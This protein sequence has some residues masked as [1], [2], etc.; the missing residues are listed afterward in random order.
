MTAAPGLA[1]PGVGRRDAEVLAGAAILLVLVAAAVLA[2]VLT[3]WDPTAVDLL[4]QHESVSAAHLLGTDHLGRDVLARVLHAGRT[5][6]A[7]AAGVTVASGV[8]GT[9]L[10][11][12]C[13][14]L[15]GPLPAVVLRLVDVVA[16]FPFLV[17]VLAVLAVTGPGLGGVLLAIPLTGWISYTRLCRTEIL[18]LREDG[19]VD[20]HRVLG[21]GGARIL[22]RHVLPHALGPCLVYSTS[23][24]TGNLVLIAA[25]SYLGAGVQPPT[26]EWGAMIAE[27]QHYLD[28]GWLP[29]V[30]A[31]AAVVVAGLGASLLGDGLAH[32]LRT[33]AAGAGA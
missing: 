23:D 22:L 31:T 11:A 32:R 5:D 18:V 20:A 21:L 33:P 3:R 28:R 8:L 10:G 29:L 6:L 24:F 13:G 7:V 17:L 4:H 9:G 16:A 25:V 19:L 30:A 12:L 1:S 27:G 2:P 14:W 26:P 15:R